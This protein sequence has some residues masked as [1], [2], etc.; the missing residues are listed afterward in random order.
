MAP[1]DDDNFL[2]VDA[3]DYTS[4]ASVDLE[5]ATVWR[6][7]FLDSFFSASRLSPKRRDQANELLTVK[8]GIAPDGSLLLRIDFDFM[9][10]TEWHT[11][12]GSGAGALL[13]AGEVGERLGHDVEYDQRHGPTGWEV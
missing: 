13:I 7:R 10:S 12:D 6:E 11:W 1:E 8:R 9:G 4:L 2:D 5:L 3:A